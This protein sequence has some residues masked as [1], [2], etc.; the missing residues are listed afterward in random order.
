MNIFT[1]SFFGHRMIDNP[2]PVEEKTGKSN[3]R[4]IVWPRVCGVSYWA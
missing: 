3:T 2:F 1:V 4:T